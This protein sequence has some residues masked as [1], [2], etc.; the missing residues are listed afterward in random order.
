MNEKHDCYRENGCPYENESDGDVC[1]HA[2]HRDALALLKVQEPRMNDAEF[3]T[4]IIS[5]ICEYAIKNEMEPDDTLKAVAI[6]IEM[7]LKIS[8]FNGWKVEQEA[9][10]E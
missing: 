10:D 5:Q 1:F 3:L 8:T 4:H 7:L 9:G 2:L 6:N